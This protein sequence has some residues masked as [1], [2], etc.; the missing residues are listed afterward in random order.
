MG[1][2]PVRL[3]P[4][5]PKRTRPGINLSI[6]SEHGGNHD[7]T[8]FCHTEVVLHYVSYS[9]KRVPVACLHTA[10]MK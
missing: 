7:S 8:K 9:P 5:E 6:R 4:E 2:S 1:C 10:K 3:K